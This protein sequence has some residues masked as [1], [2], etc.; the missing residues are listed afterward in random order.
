MEEL[1]LGYEIVTYARDATTRLAPPE[2]KNIH[3]LGKSPVV[4]D[5]DLLMHESGAITDHFILKYGKGKLA[6]IVG[7]ADYEKYAEWLHYAEGS[8]MLPLLLRLYTSRL[9]DAAAPLMPR[10]DSET[11]N[12]FAFMNS[13]MEGREFFVGDSLTGADIMMS[14]PLEAARARGILVTYPALSAFVARVQ[15][16]PAYLTALEKGGHYSYGPATA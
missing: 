1:G 16:R 2:L 4:T 11:E 3:P 7:S 5:D 12:H 8:A 14:F 6:P 15:S 10:I 13:E 9:G